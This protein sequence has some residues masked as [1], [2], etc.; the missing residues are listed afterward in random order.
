MMY[1]H[2]FSPELGLPWGFCFGAYLLIFVQPQ[3]LFFFSFFPPDKWND[4]VMCIVGE[5]ILLSAV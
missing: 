4:V 1:V 5:P 2:S 3:R